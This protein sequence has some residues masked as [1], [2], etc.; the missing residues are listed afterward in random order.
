MKRADNVSEINK[1][2]KCVS[3][4]GQVCSCKTVFGNDLVGGGRCG[5]TWVWT[6]RDVFG[7]ELVG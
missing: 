7:D 3:K 4:H 5:L 1:A 2:I 6:G